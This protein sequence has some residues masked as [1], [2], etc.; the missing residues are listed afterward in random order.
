[1]Y[2]SRS[3]PIDDGPSSSLFVYPAGLATDAAQED[4]IWSRVLY[5]ALYRD[6]SEQRRAYF[7]HG[8]PPPSS[9]RVAPLLVC[10]TFAVRRFVKCHQRPQLT[11]TM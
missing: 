8:Y 3:S 4:A 5:F 9:H 11:Y 2:L 6:G 1:M 10:K 7:V